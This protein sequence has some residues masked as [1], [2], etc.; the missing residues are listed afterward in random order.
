MQWQQVVSQSSYLE[1]R[2]RK[3]KNIQILYNTCDN[4]Y[5]MYIFWKDSY[6]NAKLDT[7]KN[8]F[9]TVTATLDSELFQNITT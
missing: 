1:H 7:L 5:N 4:A 2:K 3:C 9:C 6:S 8:D